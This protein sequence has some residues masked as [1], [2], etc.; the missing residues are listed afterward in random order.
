MK[1]LATGTT[2]RCPICRAYFTLRTPNQRRC[3]SRSC[4][5]AA[6]GKRT[7]IDLAEVNRRV[8]AMAQ[9][10][11]AAGAWPTGDG[12]RRALGRDRRGR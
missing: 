1:S 2:G 12:G 5:E 3:G 8:F 7:K 4:D 9:Q 6:Q 11:Q 10:R